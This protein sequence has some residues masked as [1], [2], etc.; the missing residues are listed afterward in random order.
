M[1]AEIETIVKL[2]YA[3]YLFGVIS[4]S[5]LKKIYPESVIDKAWFRR[6]TKDFDRF[7]GDLVF[8]ELCDYESRQNA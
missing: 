8:E 4:L 7:L 1:N 3:P 6:L 5:D 2:K